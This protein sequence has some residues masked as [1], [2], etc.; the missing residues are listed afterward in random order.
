MTRFCRHI[1]LPK[2][3]YKC[4]LVKYQNI[5]SDA[6]IRK[7]TR[8]VESLDRVHQLLSLGLFLDLNEHI[9]VYIYNIYR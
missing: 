5:Q 9:Y 2:S 1:S 8:R 7:P 6:K 4:I 3:K